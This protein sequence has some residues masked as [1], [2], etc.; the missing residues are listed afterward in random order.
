MIFYIYSV[1]FFCWSVSLGLLHYAIT[2]ELNEVSV[3]YQATYYPGLCEPVSQ[4]GLG[5]DYYVNLS[6]TE[7]W[8]SLLD[9]VPDSEWS[10]SK[11]LAF[12][13]FI[14]RYDR[15]RHWSLSL[16]FC[17][18]CRLSVHWWLTKS[19]QTRCSAMPKVTTKYLL[20]NF[21]CLNLYAIYYYHFTFRLYWHSCVF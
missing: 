16:M 10:M 19:M 17:Q 3:C 6:A 5:F 8:V 1:Y 18:C 9:S 13:S 14:V 21:R 7:M 12:L 2:V 20:C 4:G 15:T 11:V